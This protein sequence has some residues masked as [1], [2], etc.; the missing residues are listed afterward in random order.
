MHATSGAQWRS[1]AVNV[2]TGD[3]H[4]MPVSLQLAQHAHG[5]VGSSQESSI[6]G[7]CSPTHL[8]FD[9]LA[10]CTSPSVLP[11]NPCSSTKQP[12]FRMLDTV[13]L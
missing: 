9:R 3:E 13:P 1:C 4:I 12:N 6:N 7:N 11:L 10:M 5:I 8:V 2:Y